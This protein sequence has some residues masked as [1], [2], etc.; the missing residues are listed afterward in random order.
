MT[1][2]MLSQMIAVRKGLKLRTAAAVDVIY[3]DLQKAA[4]YAGLTRTYKPKAE[5]GDKLPPEYTNVQ[6]SVEASLRAIA[7]E[8]TKLLDVELTVDEGNTHARGRVIVDGE[9]LFSAPPT[10][11]LTVEK[12]LIDVRTAFSKVPVLDPAVRWEPDT[13]GNATWRSVPEETTRSKKVLRNHVKAEATE[14]HPAQ[15]ETYSADEI[16][17]TWELTKFS[18]AVSADTRSHLLQRVNTL[19]D[20][21]RHAI[22]EAN[23]T[24]VEQQHVGETVFAYLLG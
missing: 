10:F 13:T 8:W 21:V 2:P 1:S 6:K 9:E 3:K 22:E 15:V 4:L 20:A 11:L 5:D 7:D 19:I 14:K 17:G 12:K 16:V 24:L 18:G 23:S